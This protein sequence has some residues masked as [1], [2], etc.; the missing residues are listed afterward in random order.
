[1]LEETNTWITL[2][3]MCMYR[4]PLYCVNNRYGTVLLSKT[5]QYMYSSGVEQDSYQI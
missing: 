1:M 5:A 2:Y 3:C 4:V